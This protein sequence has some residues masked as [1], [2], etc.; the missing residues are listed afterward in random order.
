MKH[1]PARRALRAKVFERDLGLCADCDLDTRALAVKLSEFRGDALA[2]AWKLLEKE[3]SS[4]TAPSGR[5]TT[6]SPWTR[7]VSTSSR[8]SL[9]AAGRVTVGRPPSSRRGRLTSGSSSGRSS[10][11]KNRS[12]G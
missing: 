5:P 9:R 10:L 8:T 3:A 6:I 11:A 12:G 1:R 2:A 7:E 4:V